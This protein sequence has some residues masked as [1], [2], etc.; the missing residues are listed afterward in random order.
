[1]SYAN[2]QDLV[3]RYGTD[4]V[5]LVAD[6]DEDGE[7]DAE[8]VVRALADA[9]GEIDA[10]VSR[11]HELPLSSTPRVLVSLTV[12]IAMYRLSAE[13]DT[14]TDEKRQRYED[15]VRLLGRIA[16]GEVLLGTT[17]RRAGGAALIEGPQ[18]LFS[19]RSLRGLL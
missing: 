10:Y 8:V 16:S 1:M 3:A 5:L 11:R 9:A 6:R 18:R 7:I 15:A 14:L 13:A 2:Q 17:P 12:E 4:A 19:R